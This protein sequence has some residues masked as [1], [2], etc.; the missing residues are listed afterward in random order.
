MKFGSKYDLLDNPLHIV[1]KKN[2]FSASNVFMHIFN[3]SAT[4]LRSVVKVQ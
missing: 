2:T 1:C 3:M 4:Y